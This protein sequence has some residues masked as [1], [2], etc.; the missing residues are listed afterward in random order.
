MP[1]MA[2]IGGQWGDEGKGKIVDVLAEKA[3][4]VVRFSGGS[5][6][7][8]TVINE[9]GE[10]GLHMVP[11]GIFHPETLCI[12]G[13]GVV[14][15]PT[16]LLGEMD[17]LRKLGIDISR[18]L[19][20]DRAHI[21]MPYHLL[22]DSLEEEVKG[23]GAL[24]TTRKGIGPAFADKAARIGIRMGDLL[25]RDQLL[26]RLRPVLAQK[27]NLLTKV[28]GVSPLSL[29]E[30]YQQYLEYGEQLAPHIRDTNLIIQEAAD[31]G[32]AV[33]L[34]GAQGAMLDLD[35]GT[36]PYVTS[37]S[38]M[39]G[40][41]CLGAGLAP[42]KIEKVLGVFKAY[43]TRVGSGPMPTE[44]R[45]EL[46]DLIRERAWEYGT[47]TGR[48][49]RCGWFDTVVA[50]FSTRLNGFTGLAITRLDILDDF[51]K[52][53]VCVGYELDGGRCERMPSSTALLSRCRPAY[54]EL[55]GWQRPLRGLRGVEELPAEA[56]GYLDRLQELIGCPIAI[57][58]VGPTREDTIVIKSPW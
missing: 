58:S 35:Y 21:I 29:E 9:M 32:E 19:I 13:N 51:P 27:N 23:E 41:A 20:S 38:P 31:K 46:G 11:S 48:P 18:L 47:T 16:V 4:I 8:H 39:V 10:F 28:Y 36:Y 30:V 22:L 26:A 1:V 52:I 15:D 2:V 25:D 57:V 7:G 5:N 54:E 37:S 44:L 3:R 24:G 56:N 34:E 14:V 43:T 6:A 55:P 49:R 50:R 12:I 40:N 17:T 53:K 42:S 45:D 33:L